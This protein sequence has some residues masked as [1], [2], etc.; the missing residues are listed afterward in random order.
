MPSFMV[1]DELLKVFRSIPDFLD[2]LMEHRNDTS[3]AVYFS[4][5]LVRFFIFAHVFP[6]PRHF[7]FPERGSLP[8]HD[9]PDDQL[10]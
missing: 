2:L 5:Q 8:L 7:V 9:I 3:Y 4:A 10:G 1:F 6:S